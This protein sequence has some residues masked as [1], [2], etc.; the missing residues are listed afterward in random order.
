MSSPFWE[1]THVAAVVE[2][3]GTKADSIQISS[4]NCCPALPLMS[5]EARKRKS[6]N[7][8]GEF[9]NISGSIQSR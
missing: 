8:F 2:R 6:I 5:I 3:F 7:R 9:Q 4:S 1:L